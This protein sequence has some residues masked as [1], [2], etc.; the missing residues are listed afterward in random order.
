MTTTGYDA[1]GAGHLDVHGPDVRELEKEDARV[2]DGAGGV[3]RHGGEAR[4]GQRQAAEL[5]L[6]G[7]L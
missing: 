2:R 7:A 6:T 1:D 5:A 4:E 3:S